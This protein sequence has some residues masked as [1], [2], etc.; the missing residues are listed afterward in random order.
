MASHGE[1]A[2]WAKY[3]VLGPPGAANAVVCRGQTEP[4]AIHENAPRGPASD[5]KSTLRASPT[6]ASS[7]ASAIIPWSSFAAAALGAGRPAHQLDQAPHSGE[8]RVV[9]RPEIAG[10]PALP[11]RIARGMARE[12][13]T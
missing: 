12:L 2:G 13:R 5:L 1:L 3:A 7:S 4:R 10:A 6:D 11:A 9:V 8:P